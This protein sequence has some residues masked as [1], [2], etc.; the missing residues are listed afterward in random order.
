[1]EK[2]KKYFEFT[3]TI[4]G[5]NYLLRNIIASAT[6]FLGGF[7]IGYGLVESTELIILGLLILVP[8][9]WLSLTNIYKRFNALY[10]RNAEEYTIGLLFLQILSGFGKEQFWGNIV[11][12]VL[13]VIACVLIFRN[14]NITNHE[15]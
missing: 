2:F 6:A 10:P 13:I 3:G 11:S 14:S 15:G 12:L 9:C 1:M 8:A 4:S 7:L 5:V